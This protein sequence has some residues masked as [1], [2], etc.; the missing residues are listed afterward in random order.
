MKPLKLIM[1]AFGPYAGEQEIDFTRLGDN[2]FFLIHGPTGAGKTTILDAITFALYGTPSGDL[3]ES[4]ALRSDYAPA[5]RKTEVEFTFQ[6][7]EKIYKILRSPEQETAKQRGEGTRKLPAAAALYR[8]HND[9]SAD[10]LAAKS[11]EATKIITQLMGFKA[12]QFRQIVLLPQGEFRRFLIAE[13]KDRKAILE[14]IFKTELYRRIE[15]LLGD[16]SQEIKKA[17]DAAKTRQ[18]FLLDSTGCESSDAAA[19]KISAL[20]A[21]VSTHQENIT[22]KSTQLE[23]ARLKLQQAQTIAAAFDEYAEAGAALARLQTQEEYFKAQQ[24]I[25]DAAEQAAVLEPVFNATNKVYQQLQSALKA[26]EN[27]ASQLANAQKQSTELA[28]SL[29]QELADVEDAGNLDGSDV[30][31]ALNKL[32]EHILAMTAQSAALATSSSQLQKLASQ[33]TEGAPCPVCGSTHHPSPANITARQKGE[34]EAK[35]AALKAKTSRLQRL[36]QD[37]QKYTLLLASLEAQAQAAGR[38]A[39][40]AKAIFDNEQ[41]DFD[42]KINASI[43]KG[44]R[45]AFRTAMA[46]IPQKAALQQQMQAYHEQMAAAA[47]RMHRAENAICGQERPNEAAQ[48]EAARALEAEVRQLTAQS[49]LIRQQA[50]NLRTTLKELQAIQQKMTELEISYRTA[51]NLAET[52]KGSNSA[53]LTFSG[54]VLQSILDDV[55]AAAN[56]RLNI[57]SRSRYSLSRAAA[58][59]D[60]RRENGLNI[61]VTDTF[62][63]AARPVKTLSGGEIFLASLSLALGL[64]DVVQA[65]AGGIRLDTIL[66]DEG[67]GSLDSDSLDMAINTLMDLQR[68]GRLVG[69]ISHVAELKER[70]HARLEVIPG[71]RGSSAVLHVCRQ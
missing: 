6:N 53:R 15:T 51:A 55:L 5:S 11:D 71:Q 60:A 21:E 34:L 1:R 63:G 8:L 45:T 23:L 2:N 58:V 32:N 28:Q 31:A 40:E 3:R 38:H 39:A 57:M 27:A 50:E 47:S 37:Y 10:V 41:Q 33:L 16:R 24:Q 66:I 42:A 19:A 48:H 49:A 56:Q 17:Y 62:T 29:Q 13:S 20:E 61:E 46:N 7:G 52:A 22:A 30:A 9:G 12:E 18:Q 44:D 4:K 68:G 26:Q 35:A 70:I 69:I 14:T 25:I 64:S 36:Q 59:S 54:F 67:F 65:Y 43:F